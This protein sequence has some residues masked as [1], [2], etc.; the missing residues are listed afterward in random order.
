MR[1]EDVS[2]RKLH[3]IPETWIS[4]VMKRLMIDK[5]LV[6]RN[7]EF[8]CKFYG[9][10]FAIDRK[11]KLS[12]HEKNLFVNPFKLFFYFITL[13]SHLRFSFCQRVFLF[14]VFFCFL[15]ILKMDAL[16]IGISILSI[17]LDVYCR[18]RFSATQENCFSAI[19]VS[20]LWQ[21]GITWLHLLPVRDN[22]NIPTRA[23]TCISQLH[24]AARSCNV[25]VSLRSSNTSLSPL[26]CSFT[27]AYC[28][29][30]LVA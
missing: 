21:F 18:R 2:A 9:R 29:F 7:G 8:P 12:L 22:F 4:S 30:A 15:V 5:A 27:R 20:Q 28:T 19:C 3:K 14:I 25:L 24:C 11:I 6:S 10:G 23:R 13:S 1:F 17:C 26:F 16:T